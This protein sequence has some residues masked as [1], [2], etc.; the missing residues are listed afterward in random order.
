MHHSN[1][2]QTHHHVLLPYMLKKQPSN[3]KWC[4]LVISHM[5]CTYIPIA[6]T[7]NLWIILQTPLPTDQQ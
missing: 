3:K 6:V 1:P 5:P 4:C 7:S 2:S